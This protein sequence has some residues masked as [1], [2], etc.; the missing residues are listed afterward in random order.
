MSNDEDL[1]RAVSAVVNDCLRVAAGEQV[2]VIA[3]PATELLLT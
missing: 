2:L 1:Q 3:N